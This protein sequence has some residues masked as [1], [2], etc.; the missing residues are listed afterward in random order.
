MDA[1]PILLLVSYKTVFSKLLFFET[2]LF[3]E[4]SCFTKTYFLYKKIMH[5]SMQMNIMATKG[6]SI[7]SI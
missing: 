6:S 2:Q 3:L 5:R 7:V 1:L 4:C